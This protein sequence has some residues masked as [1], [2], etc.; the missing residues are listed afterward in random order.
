M[1]GDN[2]LEVGGSY[3]PDW[4]FIERGTLDVVL[5]GLHQSAPLPNAAAFDTSP[6]TNAFHQPRDHKFLLAKMALLAV[7]GPNGPDLGETEED[8][9]H[10][11]NAWLRQNGKHEVSKQ[12]L[13]RAKRALRTKN[14][15]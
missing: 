3:Q 7:Y 9:F 6:S 14:Q 5:N 2:P 13:R 11:V 15:A 12:T 4:I 1:T 10:K 8:C